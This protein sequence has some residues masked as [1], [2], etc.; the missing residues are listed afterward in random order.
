MSVQEDLEKARNRPDDLLRAVLEDHAE[1]KE[2]FASVENETGDERDRA[3][4][5]LMRKLVVHETAEQEV[6]HPLLG[7]KDDSAVVAEHLEQEKKGEKVL[8]SLESMGV[9]DEDF[10]EKFRSLKSDVLEHAESEEQNE[11]PLIEERVEA[12]ELEKLASVF[13]A[14]ERIAPTHPHPHGPTS[15]AGNAAVG[16]IVALMDRVRDAINS[17]RGNSAER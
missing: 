12:G 4:G 11:F 16:P 17:A 1:I 8:S 2:L 5:L 10:D 9:G 6:M 15:A 13:R 3:F 14:A 7:G